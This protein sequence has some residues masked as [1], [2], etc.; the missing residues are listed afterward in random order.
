ML[1]V[2]FRVDGSFQHLKNVPLSSDFSGSDEKLLS[3]KLFLLYTQGDIYLLFISRLF[4]ASLSYD[5][6]W[7][8]FL[9]VYYIWS[10][11]SSLN[12]WIYLLANLGNL[13]P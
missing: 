7:C 10:S 8:G 13:E 2:K 6:H 12:T 5:A 4:L 9:R 11:L 3:F 1:D